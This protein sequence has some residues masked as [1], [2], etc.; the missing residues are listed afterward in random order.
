VQ[1]GSI[2]RRV[3]TANWTTPEKTAKHLLP[4]ELPGARS[5]SVFRHVASVERATSARS[6]L[7]S[8]GVSGIIC[9]AMCLREERQQWWNLM[10]ER[11]NATW[12]QHRPQEDSNATGTDHPRGV[13]LHKCNSHSYKF[14]PGSY[15]ISDGRAHDHGRE[16]YPAQR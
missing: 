5:V 14:R 13:H 6:S 7:S 8:G 15:T 3:Q 12:S 10:C 9:D 1:R 16:T 2:R 11:T 4:S